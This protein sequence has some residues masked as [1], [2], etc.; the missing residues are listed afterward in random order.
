VVLPAVTDVN[1]IALRVFN[2]RLRVDERV[3]ICLLPMRDGL[4]LARKK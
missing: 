2:E 1:V 3:E 4:T